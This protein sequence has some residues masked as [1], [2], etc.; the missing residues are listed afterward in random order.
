MNN[1]KK[2]LFIACIAAFLFPMNSYGE[3]H[4]QCCETTLH[5]TTPITG[6]FFLPDERTAFIPI[7]GGPSVLLAQTAPTREE[8]PV[9]SNYPGSTGSTEERFFP[10]GIAALSFGA[11]YWPGLH[12]VQTTLP[13]N[14][15]EAGRPR[16]WGGNVE[17]ALHFKAYSWDSWKLLLGG[18]L[19]FLFH[20]NT[21]TFN[22]RT[23]PSGDIEKARFVSTLINMTPSLKLMGDYQYVRP[24]IGGGMGLYLFYF[25][26]RLEDS[27][28]GTTR[29]EVDKSA[30]GGY[31]SLG[32]D[33]PLQKGGKGFL[34]RIEDKVHVV[35][36]GKIE[37]SVFSTGSGGLHGPI[38]VIQ[39]G[40]AYGF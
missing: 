40:I 14:S 37:K 5:E 17:F 22:V 10:R 24:F 28:G 18:D 1:V 16:A 25:E 35:D 12:N 32:L 3:I 34:L 11:G 13:F 2:R 4:F 15:Q 38:N 20:R 23:F 7:P 31:V 21:K 39:I 6:S 30:F 29:E 27:I 26:A 19:G 36:F 8:T 33:I 9:A